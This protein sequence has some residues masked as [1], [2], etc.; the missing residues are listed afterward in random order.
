MFAE[1]VGRVELIFENIESGQIY[2]QEC[3]VRVASDQCDTCGSNL[4]DSCMQHHVRVCSVTI[5]ARSGIAPLSCNYCRKT[6]V[7]ICLECDEAY[8][9]TNGLE[10]EG[11]FRSVHRN[12]KRLLH[13]CIPVINLIN[14]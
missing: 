1:L 5:L 7:Y 10:S 12:G 14:K 8:C 9:D 3:S 13:S 2:C 6:P 4:C 11:C